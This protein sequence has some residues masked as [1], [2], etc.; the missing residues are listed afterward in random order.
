M[1][2]RTS[3]RR[4]SRRGDSGGLD[5][6]QNELLQLRK[7][8]NQR[9]A[10]LF[11]IRN[12]PRPADFN[13]DAYRSMTAELAALREFFSLDSDDPLVFAFNN[14]SD[15]ALRDL[16]RSRRQVTDRQAKRDKLQHQLRAIR[17]RPPPLRF[18][19]LDLGTQ[20]L[21]VESIFSNFETSLPD[22]HRLLQ[23]KLSAYNRSQD[24]REAEILPRIESLR[25]ELDA[26]K[27]EGA[28]LAKCRR[29][30]AH[31]VIK[32]PD[33]SGFKKA[34]A[35][36]SAV[37]RLLRPLLKKRVIAFNR[38]LEI[39]SNRLD[40][41]FNSFNLKMAALKRKVQEWQMK[42]G[43]ATG[44]WAENLRVLLRIA[45]RATLLERLNDQMRGNFKRQSAAF[46]A[47]LETEDATVGDTGLTMAAMRKEIIR[48]VK[49]IFRAN[50]A[51]PS[52]AP[53]IR[54]VSSVSRV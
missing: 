19:N 48:M 38:L 27:R 41:A 25:Q 11:R 16:N 51:Q 40:K 13:L 49:E 22:V 9:K 17:A 12:A 5:K 6:K 26:V 14:G 44:S 31:R 52:A 30:L 35:D 32:D 18:P 28:R 23:D 50:E 15:R 47:A 10:L 1:I 45:R 8:H 46:R 53:E 37:I 54:A 36:L 42:T 29:D 2:L 39:E 20:L 7:V 24:R 3:P 4:G 34:R 21:P 33:G 43:R